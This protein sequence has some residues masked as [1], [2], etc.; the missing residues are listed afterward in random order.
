MNAHS[1]FRLLTSVFFLFALFAFLPLSGIEEWEKAN[2]E[3]AK[4]EKAKTLSER[5]MAFN[6]ALSTYLQ[7]ESRTHPEYSNGKLYYNIGNAYFQLQEFPLAIFYYYKALNLRPSD[8]KVKSN[9]R[10]ALS[11][12]G[13]KYTEKPF[14]SR[15]FFYI[16]LPTQLQILFL[17]SIILFLSVIAYGWYWSKRLKILAKIFLA[18]WLFV[19]ASVSYIRFISPVEGV[20]I[21]PTQLYRDAGEQYAKAMEKPIISGE[22]V[23]VLDSIQDG[24]WLK[25]VTSEGQIGYIP[26]TALR[27]I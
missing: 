16:P 25:V 17:L 9:L 21:N 10:A 15:L 26:V 5:Q 20:I 4:G 12:V 1:D 14:L 3:Y 6:N 13:L 19:L 7:L 27:I 24:L 18:L 11:K 22:K 23:R 8:E 2:E